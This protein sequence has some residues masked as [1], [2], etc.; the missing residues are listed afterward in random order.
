MMICDFVSMKNNDHIIN[1]QS[2]FLP[3]RYICWN[4]SLGCFYHHGKQ[5]AASKKDDM[6]SD[7][8]TRSN[9]R[10]G[11]MTSRH[12]NQEKNFSNVNR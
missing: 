8:L 2:S 12:I 1:L 7:S 10:I 5:N 6:Q 4:I 3:H 11:G 9:L